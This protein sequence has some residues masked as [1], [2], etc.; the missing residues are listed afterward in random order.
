MKL[1]VIHTRVF[2]AAPDGGNPWPVVLGAEALP[3]EHMQRLARDYGLD[4]AFILNPTAP[5]AG[6][7]IRY[8]VPE[9]EIG[10]SGHASIAAVTVALGRG[11]L[12]GGRVRLQTISGNFDAA[13]EQAGGA[14]V[15]TVEQKALSFGARVDA[16]A[17]ARALGIA[18]RDI[19]AEVGREMPVPGGD[20][21]LPRKAL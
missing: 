17:A 21:N 6:L 11:L 10:I 14:W 7:R 5:A 1:E 18:P 2:A 4:T 9:R 19:D 20:S 8:F 16:D 13:Y 12:R 3:Q 15:V